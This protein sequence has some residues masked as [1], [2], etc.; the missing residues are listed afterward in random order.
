VVSPKFLVR[1][2]LRHTIKR[3]LAHCGAIFTA[4][5]PAG[6]GTAK[7][8][9]RTGAMIALL[10]YGSGV[11]FL[12]LERLQTQVGVPLPASTQWGIVANLASSGRCTPN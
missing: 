1:A 8:D 6:V 11:P 3:S 4:P 12:R 9:A 2:K 5:P 10:K 7:Y